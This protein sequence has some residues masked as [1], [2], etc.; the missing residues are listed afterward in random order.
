MSTERC[1]ACRFASQKYNFDEHKC[2]RHAPMAAK[3]ESYVDIRLWVPVFP[4]VRSDDWCGDFEWSDTTGRDVD[5]LT[6]MVIDTIE[7]AAVNVAAYLAMGR[8]GP[9]LQ[10]DIEAET[11]LAALSLEVRKR[12]PDAPRSTEA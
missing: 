6:T 3:V 8:I 12:E 5:D 2:R 11:V 1:S 9:T 10:G 4:I 7:K